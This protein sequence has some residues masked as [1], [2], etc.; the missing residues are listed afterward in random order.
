[1]AL[2]YYQDIIDSR[3]NNHIFCDPNYNLKGK[4]CIENFEGIRKKNTRIILL[5]LLIFI[6]IIISNY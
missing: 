1:M 5:I 2:T 4:R 6:L 3:Y